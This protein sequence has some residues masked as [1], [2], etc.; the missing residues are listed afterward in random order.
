MAKVKKRALF[1][2]E[3]FKTSGIRYPKQD[4][5]SII[6]GYFS[7]L[8]KAEMRMYDYIKERDEWEKNR[9]SDDNH[10]YLGFHITEIPI[11]DNSFPYNDN[12]VSVRSYTPD[13]NLWDKCLSSHTLG[14]ESKFYGREPK[15][16]RFHKGDIV[17]VLFG[18]EFTELG[19]VDSE[20]P[21]IQDY[22]RL[23]ERAPD[24]FF[25]DFT[26][27]SYTIYYLGEGDTHNH[28]KCTNIFPP[29]KPVSKSLKKRL[30]EKLAEMQELYSKKQ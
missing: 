24:W 3:T 23:A 11:D 9:D 13:G 26:D 8:K 7:T 10:H 1:K 12:I 18:G 19:I 14:E 22:E 21:S 5:F 25:M 4:V 17:E 27:D 20:P 30:R 29:S 28:P 15:D 16:I 6:I 2:L